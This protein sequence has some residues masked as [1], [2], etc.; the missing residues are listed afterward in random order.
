MF[1]HFRALCHQLLNVSR[2]KTNVPQNTYT[3]SIL[4]QEISAT[5][6]SRL[7]S[8]ILTS[9]VDKKY[10]RHTTVLTASMQI[11]QLPYEFCNLQARWYFS[12]PV[13]THSPHQSS[14]CTRT[15]KRATL[16]WKNFEDIYNRLDSI[17]TCDRWTD[18]LPRHS[19][20]YAYAS[21]SKNR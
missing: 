14:D 12:H 2:Q 6:Q 13:N 17:L 4:V 7:T 11:W 9:I 10:H 1:R 3:H 20:H 19:P 21:R 5:S 15:V 8:T 18:I 16:L